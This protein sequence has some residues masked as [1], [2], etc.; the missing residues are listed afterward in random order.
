LLA[1]PLLIAVIATCA[2]LTGEPRRPTAA[3]ALLAAIA[4]LGAAWLA[5]PIPAVRGAFA[6]AS[7]LVFAR[8]I[9]LLRGSPRPALARLWHLVGIVDTRRVVP[10]ASRL[11]I[12][13]LRRV[14]GFGALALLAWAAVVLVPPL[15]WIGGAALVYALAEVAF[16][17]L[18]G[19]YR[20]VGARPPPL[21]DDPILAL[22]V[23]EFWGRRWNRVIGDWLAEHGHRPLARTGHP[24][25]G[26][27]TAFAWSAALH[28]HFALAGVGVVGAAI[29]GSFFLVH[30]AIV[31]GER[32]LYVERWPAPLARLWTASALLGTSPLFI[33]PFLG[34]VPLAG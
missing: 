22:S 25:L 33:G 30:A 18:R 11:D 12:D 31:L 10:D 34:M 32:V 4:G 3:I 27:V 13:S 29:M 24:A 19:S 26:V 17:F 8:V 23:G 14:L 28:V 6:L 7:F 9:D 1:V 5:P 20:L 2:A 21:H 15:R 16:A